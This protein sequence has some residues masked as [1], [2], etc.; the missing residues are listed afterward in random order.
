MMEMSDNARG[1][2]AFWLTVSAFL[3]S[4][5]FVAAAFVAPS[6]SG[7][8]ETA[9]GRAVDTASPQTLTLADQYGPKIIAIMAI[10]AILTAVAWLALHRKCRG[11]RRGG[12][13]AWGSIVLLAGYVLVTGFSVG[14]FAV[15]GIVLL[16][17]AAELTPRPGRELR[18]PHT[19][20]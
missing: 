8:G 13:V 19:T 1:R 20:A 18:A 9:H 4:L 3:W 15:P 16:V 14:L 10:P 2:K 12:G 5:G 7:T 11:S 6:G 17:V